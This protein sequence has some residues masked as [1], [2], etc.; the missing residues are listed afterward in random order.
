VVDVGAGR[1]T[2]TVV[3]AERARIVY[4]VESDR[5]L[6]PHLQSLA[7]HTQT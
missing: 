5:T 7:K 6:I 2:V 3:L 1:G 4:A